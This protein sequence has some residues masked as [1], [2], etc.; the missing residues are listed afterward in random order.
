M[1]SPCLSAA[2]LTLVPQRGRARRSS[3]VLPYR[4]CHQRRIVE[5]RSGDCKGGGERAS[6]YNHVRA[7]GSVLH[8]HGRRR[9]HSIQRGPRGRGDCVG[10]LAMLKRA[11]VMSEH[12]N[13]PRVGGLQHDAMY[14]VALNRNQLQPFRCHTVLRNLPTPELW[15]ARHAGGHASGRHAFQ[16]AR[17]FT[18]SA[19]PPAR[20]ARGALRH[21]VASLPLR[22]LE[23]RRCHCR[24][25]VARTESSLRPTQTVLMGADPPCA[26]HRC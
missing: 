26:L 9:L 15:Q 12:L 5:R 1:S 19:P 17:V 20:R 16:G 25:R 21:L 2:A 6:P 18:P 4:R 7:A 22:R 11:I 14:G 8:Y 3:N 23:L 24:R 10:A 13:G